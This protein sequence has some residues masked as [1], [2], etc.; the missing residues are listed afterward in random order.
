MSD[1]HELLRNISD[2]IRNGQYDRARILLNQI[3]DNPTAQEWLQKLDQLDPTPTTFEEAQADLVD[4]QAELAQAEDDIQTV[5]TRSRRQFRVG[6]ALFVFLGT[7]FGSLLGAAADF[8]DALDNVDRIRER[9]YPELCI[10]GSDTILAEDLG[11]AQRW[12]DEFGADRE[13]NI[14]IDAIGSSNGVQ[15]AADGGCAHVLAMSEAMSEAQLEKLTDADVEVTC[16]AEVG[17]D[18][19]VLVTDINNPVPQIT[20]FQLNDVLLGNDLNW[21]DIDALSGYDHPITILVR[22]GSGTTDL[23]MSNY[24]FTENWDSEGGRRFPPEARYVI[25]DSNQECLNRTLSTQGSLYWA[26]FAHIVNQPREYLRPLAVVLGDESPINP[27]EDEVELNLYPRKLVRPL[28]LY[29]LRGD[30]TDS[31]SYE[32]AVE[33]LQYVRGMQG[34]DVLDNYFFTYFSPPRDADE[35][36]VILLDGFDSITEPNRQLCLTD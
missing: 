31:D 12:A 16:M 1:E 33:F 24:I 29:V 25:C 8:G 26:S 14:S 21:L 22:S 34:Q 32:L 35:D 6:M 28:Y 23:V 4:A 10:V 17:Y 27:L 36:L 2:L 15:R 7:L 18:I 9:F 19:I 3:P 11:M 30:D 13:V 5:K 20:D